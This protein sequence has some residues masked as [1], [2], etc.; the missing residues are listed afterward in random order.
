MPHPSVRRSSSAGISAGIFVLFTGGALVGCT[1]KE[2]AAPT[3]AA[4]PTAATEA[5]RLDL[6]SG[7]PDLQP[8]PGDVTDVI[9]PR[10]GPAKPETVSETIEMAFPPEL[11]PD[12]SKPELTT[13][14]LKVERFGPTG[15]QSLIDAVRV[16]FNHPMVPL[17]AVETLATKAVPFTI[18]PQPPGKVRWLGTRTVAFYPEGRMPFSTKYEVT[19][20]KGTKSTVGTELAAASTFEFS[21]P[22]LALASA[23]PAHATVGVELEP[24]LSLT[25]NQP[26]QRTALLAALRWKGGGREVA[27]FDVTAD[28]VLSGTAALEPWQRERMVVLK[29]KAKLAPNTHYTVSLPGGVFGEGPIASKPLELSF[30]TYPPLTLATTPCYGVC[31]ASNGITLTAS[32]TIT[33]VTLDKKVHVTPAVENI[34]VSSGWQGI[35]IGGDFI[36]DTTYTV[37]VD[38]GVQ[39]VHGQIL[40][41]PFKASIKLGPQYPQVSLA[42]QQRNPAVI[43]TGAPQQLELRIA[44]IDDLEIEGRALDLLDVPQFLDAYSYDGMW[45]WPAGVAKSTFSKRHDV[46]SSRRKAQDFIVDLGAV[47]GKSNMAWLIARSN[48]IKSDGW[49]SRYGISQLVQVTDLGIAAAVDRDSGLLQVTKLSTGEP[50][51]GVELEIVQGDRMAVRLWKGTTGDDGLARASYSTTVYGDHLMVVAKHEGDV[52]FMRLDQNDLRG[53][54]RNWGAVEDTSKAFFFTDRA[55]YKPGETIHLVGLLRQE[56]RGPKGAVQW[57]RQNATAKYKVVDP[58]GIDVASGETKVGPFGTLAV[59]IE[60]KAEGGTG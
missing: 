15:E 44:G 52:A 60:T 10:P 31:W 38:A 14:P 45:G 54:W 56:T 33:D 27:F 19:V 32:N 9:V 55:P 53:A 37:V 8:H 34:S 59:D 50:L 47:L 26:V 22:A 36:G 49:E 42:T 4:A 17:A 7:V 51:P 1:D 11:P 20:P 21:T 18:D 43:E 25:F 28:P 58:R 12:A 3:E 24:V 41:K 6:W 39:D 57:W 29:P 35:S 13:G 46:K 16:T 30:D 23:N 40:A 5:V 48:K 2:E